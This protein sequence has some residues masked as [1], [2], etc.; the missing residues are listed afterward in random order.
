MATRL[1]HRFF[2]GKSGVGRLVYEATHADADP[3]FPW[4]TE[5]LLEREDGR[6]VWELSLP[7]SSWSQAKAGGR[8]L[9]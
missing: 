6:W 9:R 3:A 8:V 7:L 4:R 5:V 2:T 1:V